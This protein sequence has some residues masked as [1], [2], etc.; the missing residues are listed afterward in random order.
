MP[1]KLD[2]D[3]T[4]NKKVILSNDAIAGKQT[5]DLREAKLLRLLI[6]QINMKDKK[7]ME[8]RA[9]IKEVAAC[10]EVDDSNLYRDIQKI[11]ENLTGRKL[12]IKTDNPKNPWK[13]Y[14]WMSMAEYDGDGTLTLG[15]NE[16][17]RPFVIELS[18]LFTQYEM[19]DIL[20][21]NSFYALRIYE[22]LKKEF[23][24]RNKTK[25]VFEFTIQE[26]REITDTENKFRQIGSFRLNVIN[27]AER[28]I[29]EKTDLCISV[30]SIKKS[31]RFIGFKFTIQEKM[32]SLEALDTDKTTPI[33]IED[34]IPGQ[35]DL[36][37]IYE[38]KSL[39][40]SLKIPCSQTQ[41]ERMFTAYAYDLDRFKRNLDYVI[42]KCPDNPIAYL[43]SI[44]DEDIAPKADLP[45]PKKAEKIK[46]KKKDLDEPLS[47]ERI[48]AYLDMEVHHAEDLWPE[49]DVVGNE[50]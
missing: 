37:G 29:N 13:F 6:M 9:D 24:K 28:E 48:Q 31:R 39:L 38:I 12:G 30:D 35:I 5:M 22:V 50:D 27:I 4:K 21:I 32:K 7:L 34:P 33:K 17:I 26:L 19:I 42:Q 47:A 2:L 43:F 36:G 11:C 10:L 8:Y 25:H 23:T 40:E 14:P 49:L 1:N 3:L 16:K 15:L 41:A 20:S 18:E 45:K 46:S 44:K